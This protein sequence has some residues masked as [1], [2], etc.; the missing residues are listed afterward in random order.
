VTLTVRVAEQDD[1]AAIADIYN[2]GIE[3]RVATF[4]TEP[5]SPAQVRAVLAGSGRHP[6][7][8]AMREA[9]VVAFAWTSTYRPR[10]CYD[11]V[12]EFSVYVRRDAR[13]AGA[14][15]AALAGLLDACEAAGFSKLVSR[16]FPENGASRA[17]C[18]SLGFREVGTYLRHG[19]LDGAWRDCVIV[20]RLIGEAADVSRRHFDS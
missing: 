3:D 7:V 11:S 20:E 14:G 18:R 12:V 10:P 17:L 19:R 13:G 6:A 16:I 1:A 9:E 8:V 2:Q 4:E 5:R 15:R